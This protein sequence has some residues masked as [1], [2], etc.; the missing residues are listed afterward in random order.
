[1]LYGKKPHVCRVIYEVDEGRPA[2]WV[3]T[4]RHGVRRALG[5]TR[6]SELFPV[7]ENEIVED[8]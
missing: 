7:S 4:I 2:V 3:L 1:L 8:Y 5:K 6:A